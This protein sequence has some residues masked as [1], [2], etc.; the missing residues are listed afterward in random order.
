MVD[1]DFIGRGWAFPVTVTHNGS[2]ALVGGVA[3]LERSIRAILLTYPGERPMRPLFGSRLRDFIF[4]EI[5]PE[6]L[7]AIEVEVAEAI[8]RYEHRVVVD[9]VR[10]TADQAVQGRID[11]GIF[12][13][14]LDTNDSHNLVVPFYSI[15]GEEG[16]D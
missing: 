4:A 1:T 11:I 2:I 12:Y 9:E 16:E 7:G 3:D 15:P 10:A 6:T 5:S 13:T 8:N 14:I